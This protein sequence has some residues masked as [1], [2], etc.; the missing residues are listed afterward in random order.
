M[1][2]AGIAATTF[3]VEIARGWKLSDGNAKRVAGY[4]VIAQ[5]ILLRTSNYS[6]HTR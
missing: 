2:Q 6:S 5:Q 4:V 3:H 1:I